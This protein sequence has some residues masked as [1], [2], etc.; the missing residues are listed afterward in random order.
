MKW[1]WEFDPDEPGEDQIERDRLCGLFDHKD[2]TEYGETDAMFYH[3]RDMPALDRIIAETCYCNGGTVIAPHTQIVEQL[4]WY[5]NPAYVINATGV[6]PE[7]VLELV[8]CIKNLGY[9]EKQARSLFR[10]V[11]DVGWPITGTLRKLSYQMDCASCTK[12]EDAMNHRTDNAGDFDF[13]LLVNGKSNDTGYHTIGDPDDGNWLDD[14]PTKFRRLYRAIQHCPSLDGI[15]R[16]ATWSFEHFTPTP[17]QGAPLWDLY[18]ARKASLFEKQASAQA[19]KALGFF[20]QAAEFF[21][22]PDVEFRKKRSLIT[23]FK[24]ASKKLTRIKASFKR[25]EYSAVAKQ[26]NIAWDALNAMIVCSQERSF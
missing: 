2:W 3:F 26:R 16:I 13:N 12:G 4:R 11:K 1:K 6:K 9:T 24:A 19:K 18:K 14:Q 22:S 21:D 20:V 10:S 7:Q 15:I 8:H 25:G 23:A 17:E 5:H